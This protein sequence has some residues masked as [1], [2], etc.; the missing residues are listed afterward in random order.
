MDGRKRM[1]LGLSIAL[2][3]AIA[4]QPGGDGTL[5][6]TNPAV[7]LRPGVGLRNHR[8]A[9]R[10]SK[11][12]GS[13]SPAVTHSQPLS[14]VAADAVA[15]GAREAAAF[16]YPPAAPSNPPPPA[17]NYTPSYTP[18]YAPQYAPDLRPRYPPAYAPQYAMIVPMMPQYQAPPP[19]APGNF[20]L[21]AP[22]PSAAPAYGPPM[23]PMMPA[24]AYG[25]PMAPMMPAP[26]YGPPMVPAAPQPAMMGTVPALAGS[27]VAV[28]TSSSSSSVEIRGPGLLSAG[29]AW[30]NT[31]SS[32]AGPGSA[33]S[34][35][36]CFRHL[37]HSRWAAWPRSRRAA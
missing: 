1:I 14:L 16:I 26:A 34:S 28:P 23:A 18:N 4:A 29:L 10:P 33:P 27:S 31:S 37:G 35:R 8:P 32:W 15:R 24:P 5:P 30:E 19:A 22:A 6:R 9:R 11:S 17:P 21:P 2:G 20:F 13:R 12:G 3:A 36:P 25:P 7:G